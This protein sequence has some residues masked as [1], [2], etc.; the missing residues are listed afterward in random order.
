M[1]KVEYAILALQLE[2][3]YSVHIDPKDDKAIGEHCEMIA[4]FIED[5]G[6]TLEEFVRESLKDFLPP[7]PNK[8]N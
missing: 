4:R 6:W 3:L 7:D 2:E 1:K 8:M 5:A